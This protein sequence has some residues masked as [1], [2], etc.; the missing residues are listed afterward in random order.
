MCCV[1]LSH[2]VMS[3]SLEPHRLQPSRLLCP[4][5]FSRQEYWSRLPCP[6]PGDLPNLGIKLRSPALQG[7]SLLSD[8]P[9]KPKYINKC[10]IV[11]IISTWV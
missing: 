6:S 8:P 5:T 3:D 4:L 7:D 2:S 10:D 11:L 9:G 1:V